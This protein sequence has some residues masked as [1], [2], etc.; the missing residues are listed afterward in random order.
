MSLRISSIGLCAL[1]V[2][3]CGGADISPEPEGAL[4]DC[5]IGAGAEMGRDCTLERVSLKDYVIHH[6]G[7][8]FR[9]FVRME[10][11]GNVWL[12]PADGADR[13]TVEE[14]SKDGQYVIGLEN[15]SYILAFDL[16]DNSQSR[17]VSGE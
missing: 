14:R 1:L 12:E 17:E 9:R 10:E 11:E 13:L 8:G 5:A 6:P 3:A 4:I 2:A 15:E 7:G 16:I